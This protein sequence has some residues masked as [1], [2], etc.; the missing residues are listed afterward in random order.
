MTNPV[1]NDTIQCLLD[2]RSI[3]AFQDRP[4]EDKQIH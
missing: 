4:I 1:I 3:R 2:H